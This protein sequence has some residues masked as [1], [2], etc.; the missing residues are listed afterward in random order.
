MRRQVTTANQ[1]VKME[2]NH[3]ITQ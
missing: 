2:E 1:S 3:R